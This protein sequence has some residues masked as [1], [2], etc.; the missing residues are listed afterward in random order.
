[1]AL[2]ILVMTGCSIFG[3]ASHPVEDAATAATGTVGNAITSIKGVNFGVLDFIAAVCALG[4]AASLV[5]WGLRMP[6]PPKLTLALVITTVGAWVLKLILVKFL[7][8]IMVLSIVGLLLAGAVFAY[9]HIGWLE[10]RLNKDLNKNGT[11]GS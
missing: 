10:K 2:G 3:G 9:T 6:V 8:I 4:A 5:M 7:W 11:V 1:M